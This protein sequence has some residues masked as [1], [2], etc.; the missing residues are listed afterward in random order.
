MIEDLKNFDIQN[1]EENI[2][3]IENNNEND[4]NNNNSFNFGVKDRYG[5]YTEDNYVQPKQKTLLKRKEK[6][7]ER[8]KK[9]IKMLKNWDHYKLNKTLKLK[10]RIRKGIPDIVRSKVWFLLVDANE[11]KENYSDLKMLDINNVDQRTVDEVILLFCYF[12]I[13]FFIN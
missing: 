8:T 10:N 2:E 7:S 12:I 4:I 13:F 6:E 1:N 3:N 5:F 11:V 9:W